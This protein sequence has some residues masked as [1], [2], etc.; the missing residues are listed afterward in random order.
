[1]L[2]EA[3]SLKYSPEFFLIWLIITLYY[4]SAVHRIA[5]N[6]NNEILKVLL[7]IQ[8]CIQE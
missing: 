3:Q 6:K 4:P 8:K 5:L 7:L 1:M 2:K